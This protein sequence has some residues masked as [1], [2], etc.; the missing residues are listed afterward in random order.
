M[1]DDNT[2]NGQSDSPAVDQRPEALDDSEGQDARPEGLQA[3]QQVLATALVGMGL[4]GWRRNQPVNR[5]SSLWGGGLR[6]ARFGTLCLRGETP[7][8]LGNFVD[9]SDKPWLIEQ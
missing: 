3:A 6:K 9:N 1:T 2:H 7:N 4:N 5:E 8:R